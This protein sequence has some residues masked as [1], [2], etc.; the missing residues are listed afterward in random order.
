MALGR[1]PVV[2]C[3]PT[4]A[5]VLIA[6]ADEARLRDRRALLRSEGHRTLLA[7][8][9]PSALDKVL[10]G[11]PALVLADTALPELDGYGLALSIREEYDADTVRIVLLKE[12][13]AAE[14]RTTAR[15]VGADEIAPRILG[16]DGLMDIVRT[17]L[18][19]R[20]PQ[21]G[22]LAGQGD[23]ESLFA[24]LQF[25]HQR[26]ETG[27]LSLGGDRPGT[28]VFAGGEIIGARTRDARGDQA[29]LALLGRGEGRYCFDRGL[30]DPSARCIERA[31]DPLL[32]DA[33]AALA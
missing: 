1:G 2:A 25:L 10:A 9:G 19:T 28:I 21:D 17:V 30:V 16:D 12:D 15:A 23:Q 33:F 31:F 29:F 13:V 3:D 22:A 20:A 24:I 14:D 32:M 18:A 11:H 26:R 5:T 4:M 6:D 7:S 8:D 27:T